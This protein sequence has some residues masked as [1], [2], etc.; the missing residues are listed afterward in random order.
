MNK[1]E[2]GNEGE[3]IAAKFLESKGF[4]I[5]ERNWRFKHLEID[6]IAS[7]KNKL[8]FVE[9]KTRTSNKFGMPEQSIS[10]IK[11][12][13]LKLAAEAYLI[14]HQQWE[15]IQFDVVAIM[16]TKKATDI[17]LIEDVFF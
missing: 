15:K 7:M 4:N 16:Q 1:T 5:I 9:V 13:R 11:M 14:K 3:T 2:K 17:F 6:I 10:Q 12:D 8:H